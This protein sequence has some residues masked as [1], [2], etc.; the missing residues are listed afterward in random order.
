MNPF[1][2]SLALLLVVFSIVPSA[3]ASQFAEC[4]IDSYDACSMAMMWSCTRYRVYGRDFE[5]ENYFAYN[6]EKARTRAGAE[7][8]L[9]QLVNEGVCPGKHG[10]LPQSTMDQK[11]IDQADKVAK[12]LSRKM[13]RHFKH[14]GL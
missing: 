1:R 3:R 4:M 14:S 7:E 13:A 12:K 9:R 2:S 11:Y 8:K 6:L 10:N 5:T